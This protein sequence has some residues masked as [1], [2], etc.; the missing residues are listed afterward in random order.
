MRTAAAIKR[1]AIKGGGGWR[2][3]IGMREKK[4]AQ[5]WQPAPRAPATLPLNLPDDEQVE[6][7]PGVADPLPEV[8][9]AA[10]VFE[11]DFLLLVEP[12]ATT[13]HTLNL[14]E[15]QFA[16][17]PLVGWRNKAEFQLL[18]LMNMQLRGACVPNGIRGEAASGSGES[19]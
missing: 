8:A 19:N 12:T 2:C 6:E 10:A 17:G 18:C 15:R 11:V 5:G 9:A 14:A 4:R 1:K 7:P 16:R 3:R 13:Y